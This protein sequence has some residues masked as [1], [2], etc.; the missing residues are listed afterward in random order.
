MLASVWC[1]HIY[2]KGLRGVWKVCHVRDVMACLCLGN[3]LNLKKVCQW[4]R[5]WCLNKFSNHLP[6]SSIKS[7]TLSLQTAWTSFNPYLHSGRSS[8]AGSTL[9]HSNYKVFNTQQGHCDRHNAWHSARAR[10]VCSAFQCPL[11]QGCCQPGRCPA[12][13]L[14]GLWGLT[15]KAQCPS[16]CLSS[17]HLNSFLGAE[18]L[19]VDLRTCS[20][21]TAPPTGTLFQSVRNLAK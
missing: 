20:G 8:S 17:R 14:T 5:Q 1:C 12:D 11:H 18:L 10:M 6:K 2:T 3:I 9:V 21:I 16:A 7:S 13:R 19:G 4:E 15:V